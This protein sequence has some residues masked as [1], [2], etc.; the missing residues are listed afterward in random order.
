MQGLIRHLVPEP[1]HDPRGDA[2]KVGL[3]KRF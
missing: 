2:A 1:D 3:S